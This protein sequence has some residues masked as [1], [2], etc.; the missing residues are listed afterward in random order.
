MWEADRRHGQGTLWRADGTKY[1]GTFV[2]DQKH[3]KGQLFF[4]DGTVN[5]EEWQNG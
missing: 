2:Y 4:P 5:V 3:G 1:V